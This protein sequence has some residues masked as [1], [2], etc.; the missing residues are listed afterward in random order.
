[1]NLKSLTSIDWK[2]GMSLS[3]I[4]QPWGLCRNGNRTVFGKGKSVCKDPN[5]EANLHILRSSPGLRDCES[6]LVMDYPGPLRTHPH[7]AGGRILRWPHA[8]HLLLWGD[9]WLLAD[10]GTGK[11][12]LQVWLRSQIGWFWVT[13]RGDHPGWAWLNQGRCVTR[14]RGLFLRAGESAVGNPRCWVTAS[15]L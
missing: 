4:E 11:R 14:S 9:L 2:E 5:D 6:S 8:P 12:I 1:M 7:L 3:N 10:H 15:S 13:P